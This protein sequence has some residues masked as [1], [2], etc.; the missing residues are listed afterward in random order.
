MKI[1][2]DLTEAKRFLSKLDPTADNFV[3]QVFDDNGDRK[4]PRLARVIPGTLDAVADQL[5]KYQK[6]GAGVF[7][8]INRS[9]N[10]GR[11]KK[12][13]IAP[14]A[15]FREA[16][17]PN[18]P[19]LPIKPQF[20]VESSPGK[21]H[22]YL[23]LD[24]NCNDLDTWEAVM[25]TMVAVHGSDPNAK[26][27]ARVLRLPGFYH[28]KDPNHPHMVKIIHE[29]G[30][31]R[32][33]MTEIAKAIPP[34]KKQKKRN[35]APAVSSNIYAQKALANELAELSG[36]ARGSRNHQLNKA[37]FSMGQLV[38]VGALDHGQVKTALLSAAA[39]IGLR[40]NEACRTI[41]SGFESGMKEPRTFPEKMVHSEPQAP[42]AATRIEKNQ[43][44]Q[45]LDPAAPL[46]SA[47]VFVAK[48]YSKEALTTLKYWQGVF[49]SWTGSCYTLLPIDDIRADLYAFL[50]TAMV[51][52][53]NGI[54][55]FKPNRNRVSD[56][57]DAL[58]AAVNLSGEHKNPCWL[59]ETQKPNAIEII[60]L[61]NGLLHLPTRTLLPADPAFFTTSA[62]PFT[63]EPYAAP[64]ATWNK[65]L[66][67]IWGNDLESINTLQEICGY[68]LTSDTTQQ[69]I[70][71][72]VGPM[73]SGKGTIARV[74]TALLGQENV[75]GPTL[76]SLSHQF[77]LAPL[78]DKKLAVIAD[79]RLS[80]RADQHSIAE[81]LLA[82][83]GEDCLSIPRKYLADYTAK[84]A[85]RFM[86]LSNELPRL[87]DASG[88]LASRF[89]ILNMTETFLG[90]EDPALTN[91]LLAELPGILN[92][93]IKGW[94]RLMER[95]H[96]IQPKS[97]KESILELADLS[98][99]MSAFVRDRCKLDPAAE[100]DCSR[101]YAEWRDW[102]EEQGRDKPGT[103]QTFGRDLR[104]AV[105]A[106]R[107]T[108]PRDGDTRLRMYQGVTLKNTWHAMARV[109][110]HCTCKSISEEDM[111]KNHN[112]GE[113]VPLRASDT[114]NTIE[115][116][117]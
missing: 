117:I 27:I 97:S 31:G 82:I 48:Y 77:G 111:I 85:V 32:Y 54:A 17:E 38:A 46:N 106:L 2:P 65:F 86:I 25:M 95:G 72:V 68:L 33:S 34:L 8:T 105:P 99:P 79:A 92:W 83:S 55:P 51:A 24:N 98:S 81:R 22:E 12:D 109:S 69:K 112:G 91:K 40:E 110:D 70:F 19:K 58:K 9:R 7:V 11:T 62:L 49:Y 35:T 108:Q 89:V 52:G 67:S 41:K 64:P 21:Q 47:Q 60:A 10:G 96:F 80:S 74:F 5:I 15:V 114:Q 75:A 73:R 57:Q 42:T 84:L 53:K 44:E 61:E 115:V 100:V 94:Q 90:K 30:S 104:A 43:V 29:N 26:D 116:V 113:R 3:F 101:L 107:V 36:T 23:L 39:G 1:H 87:A 102:C 56:V 16:D 50:K 18:L 103:K 93:S 45:I 63:Y 14:R 4:D 76:A 66:K 71:L 6:A 13:I 28:Q 37:A 88:A 20:I 59:H 78:I